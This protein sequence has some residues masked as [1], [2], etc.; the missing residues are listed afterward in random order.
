MT[1]S[2]KQ[3]LDTETIEKLIAAS[4]S[5]QARA[6]CPYSKFPVGAAILSVD[7]TIYQGCNIENAAYSGTICAERVAMTKAVSEGQRK[8]RAMAVTTDLDYFS[9]PCGNCRQ[10]IVEVSYRID[11]LIKV[12]INFVCHLTYRFS[13]AKMSTS[14]SPKRMA[15]TRLCLS[16][17]CC[18][19]RL[20]PRI[21]LPINKNCRLIKNKSNS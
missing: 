17:N 15:P 12:E 11:K 21:C 8:F 20:G 6:Y 10:F 13:L 3:V 1:T 7:G 19:N 14:F 5:A 2:S 9:S 18:P 16:N 4:R